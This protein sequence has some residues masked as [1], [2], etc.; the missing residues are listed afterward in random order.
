MYVVIEKRVLVEKLLEPSKV[1]ETPVCFTYKQFSGSSSEDNFDEAVYSNKQ[2]KSHTMAKAANS[3]RLVATI[4]RCN[5]RVFI[6]AVRS[7]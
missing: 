4:R 7:K 1:Y 6:L 3:P 2:A 5:T